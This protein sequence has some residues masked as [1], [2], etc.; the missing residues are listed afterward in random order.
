MQCSADRVSSYI[1][2]GVLPERMLPGFL[3]AWRYGW[4]GLVLKVV[5]SVLGVGLNRA[6]GLVC[7]AGIRESGGEG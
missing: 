4:R 3:F 1:P 5:R 7:R 6:N 2:G